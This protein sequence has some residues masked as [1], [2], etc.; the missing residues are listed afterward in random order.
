MRKTGV[1]YESG[2]VKQYFEDDLGN[3]FVKNSQ[4]TKSIIDDVSRVSRSYDASKGIRK[5]MM[6]VG[7]IPNILLEQWY[8]EDPELKSNNKKL[9][10]KFQDYNY[11]KLHAVDVS[12]FRV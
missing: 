8:R 5:G 12:K 6:Y 10:K 1:D 7:S 9:L 3:M 4:D 2:I 11:S